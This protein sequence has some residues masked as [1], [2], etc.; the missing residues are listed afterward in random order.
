MCLRAA[1]C[2]DQVVIAFTICGFDSCKFLLCMLAHRPENSCFDV[3]TA[4]ELFKTTRVQKV[5][6]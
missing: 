6:T 3:D 1:V 5:Y 4:I 2:C